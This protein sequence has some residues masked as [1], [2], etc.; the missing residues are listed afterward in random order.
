MPVISR[1][2]NR[3]HFHCQ[4]QPRM[5]RSLLTQT[6]L[7]Q[8]QPELQ[9]GHQ[10][11]LHRMLM[12]LHQIYQCVSLLSPTACVASSPTGGPETPLDGTPPPLPPTPLPPPPTP[13]PASWPP[14][15]DIPPLTPA[16]GS[17]PAR[18][19]RRLITSWQIDKK[20]QL[21]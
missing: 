12:V 6:A 11:V 5:Q 14:D 20:H 21:K 10:K 17:F 4:Q 8:P 7:H 9:M 19:E 3:H 18:E 2:L 15:D 13:P 1:P 16:R